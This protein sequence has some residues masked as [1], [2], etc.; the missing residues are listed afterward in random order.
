MPIDIIGQQARVDI[1][2]QTQRFQ[3]EDLEKFSLVSTVVIP[4]TVNLMLFNT[5]G[6]TL[7]PVA[8]Q[9]GLTVTVSA[10]AASV[11]SVGLFY[12]NRQMPTSVGFYAYEWRMFGSS[13]ATSGTVAASLFTIRR[14][15]FEV[16]K[17]EPVSFFTYGNAAEV[18]R[19]ARQ[20]V[21]R[22]D[23]TQRDVRPH[24]EAGD[25]WIDSKL[26][27]II[28][29]PI[30]P[31]PLSVREMSN[32][33]AIYFLY[34]AY[35]GGQQVDEPPAVVR[36]FDKDNEFLDGVVEGKYA[37]AG[38]GVSF[39]FEQPVSAIT[40]GVEGGKPAFGRSDWEEQQMDTAIL[41]F[42]DDERS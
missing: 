9:S 3:S 2:G 8:V 39:I 5:D 20:L 25:G 28:T 7:A 31:A 23:V 32:R 10:I 21:G 37:L 33:M 42:E 22:G 35:Y 16:F 11:G 12:V 14:G 30:S 17:T 1:V 29:V 13:G 15:E 24:M 26:G 19:R 34:N 6:A 41:D 18:M 4:S 36:Q 27:K 40:G 38:S